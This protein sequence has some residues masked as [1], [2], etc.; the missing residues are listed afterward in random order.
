M[1]VLWSCLVWYLHVALILCSYLTKIVLVS[2]DST[3]YRRIQ[4]V[5]L[6]IVLY[7]VFSDTDRGPNIFGTEP[8]WYYILN[9]ILYFNVITVMAWASFP[10]LVRAFLIYLRKLIGNRKCISKYV[11]NFF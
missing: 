11:R 1:Q 5:P 6:N 9:L 4:I 3:A 2:I 7:N 10:L 8:W